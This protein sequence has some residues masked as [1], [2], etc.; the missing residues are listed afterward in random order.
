MPTTSRRRSLLRLGVLLFYLTAAMVFAQLLVGGALVFGFVSTT[1]HIRTGLFTLGFAACAAAAALASKPSY[2]PIK[3]V[4]LLLTSMV[5]VQGI[6]GLAVLA[7]GS[8][9]VTL[10][11]FTSALLIY[12]FAVSGAFLARRWSTIPLTEKQGPVIPAVLVAFVLVATLVV[13]T[14]AFPHK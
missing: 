5:I 14:Y 12:G 3:A 8:P 2:R 10:L 6:L 7:T 4:G 1:T 9:A 11:H 13:I